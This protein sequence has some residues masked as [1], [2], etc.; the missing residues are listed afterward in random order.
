M[1]KSISLSA[2]GAILVAS[3]L[4]RP[5][6]AQDLK[7]GSKAPVLSIEEWMK[8]SEVKAFQPG[9]TYV[10]EFWATWCPPCLKSIP[11]LTEVQK[12]YKD[13]KVTV[14]GV[15]ASERPKTVEEQRA[16]LVKFIAGKGDTMNYT[17]GFD[18]DRSMSETWMRAANQGGIPTCFI[19]DKT[20]TIA[21]IGSPFVMD[22]P[23]KKIV[24]GTWDPKAEAAKE[25]AKTELVEKAKTAA[26]AED[27]DGALASL[28][29]AIKLGDDVLQ[30]LAWFKYNMHV[31]KKDC[32]G[33]FAFVEKHLKGALA[34]EGDLLN[35]VAWSMVD[36]QQAKRLEKKNFD[37]ALR[38]AQ[39]SSEL[40]KGKVP[41]EPMALDTLAAVHFAKGEFAKAVEVQARAA[42][43]MK[44]Q[45]G[46]EEYV[47]KLQKYKDAAG[48]L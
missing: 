21:W 3:A 33:A 10:V 12:T 5:A 1:T 43:L 9:E 19:V 15:A 2:L 44:D 34:N 27:W 35:A 24:A 45:Q 22:A 17:I 37:L 36:E 39:R 38:C 7:M 30:E 42:E 32:D 23:L 46:V 20:G 48:K 13:S 8:G 4:A 6:T 29:E 26:N 40:A 47:E 25:L 41:D 16:G 31:E 28:D 14:I 11:H 18:S